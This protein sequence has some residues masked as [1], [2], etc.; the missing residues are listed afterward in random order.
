LGGD[1]VFFQK[2]KGMSLLQLQRLVL[3]L[4]LVLLVLIASSGYRISSL[5]SSTTF[6]TKRV[7]LGIDYG[8]RF[9][10][11]AYSDYFGTVRPMYRIFHNRCNL[12][13][14]SQK[15]LGIAK[16]RGAAEIIV[17]LPLGPDPDNEIQREIKGFNAQLSLNFSKVLGAV[18][19]HEC[20]KKMSVRLFDER[21]TTQEAQV[22]LM[23]KR[24]KGSLDA[25][26]AACILER[27][28]EDYGE[29][30]LE[31]PACS[32]PPPKDLEEFDYDV[33][34]AYIKYLYH[35]SDMTERETNLIEA[36]PESDKS[37]MKSSN[38]KAVMC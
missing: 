33:V 26:S 36:L 19:K 11:I 6:E 18:V 25:M 31:A 29:G 13:S 23:S 20:K 4:W 34:K 10:G 22:R 14:L 37:L 15:I 38:T 28:L 8:P 3:P 30:S 1:G 24:G 17:G 21:F 16:N 9:I 32:Y 27:Y 5:G 35:E 2:M 12:T 7:R